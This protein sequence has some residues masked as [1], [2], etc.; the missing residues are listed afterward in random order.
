[1]KLN[2]GSQ[3]CG[4]RCAARISWIL[5]KMKM[6]EWS[7]WIWL[8]TFCPQLKCLGEQQ[9]S[10][11]PNEQV[12]VIAAKKI[13]CFILCLDSITAMFQHIPDGARALVIVVELK[14]HHSKWGLFL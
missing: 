9:L 14:S 10:A 2:L 4:Y 13:L 11:Q 7:L 6:A 12:S 5:F 8:S 1:M 3:V